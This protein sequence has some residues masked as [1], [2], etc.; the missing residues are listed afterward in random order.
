[1]ARCAGE[2]HK[3]KVTRQADFH[4][5]GG[6]GVGA[7][8]VGSGC[9]HARGALRRAAPAPQHQGV[10][11]PYDPIGWKSVWRHRLETFLPTYK[12]TRVIVEVVAESTPQ[13]LLQAYIFVRVM[14][15]VGV[16]QLAEHVAI[17]EEASILPISIAI[18]ALNLLKVWAELLLGAR[19]AGVP[20]Q[21]WLL[22]I[23]EMGAGK[24]PLDAIRRGTIKE[25]VWYRA[26]TDAEWS[27]LV[28][29]FLQNTS[30]VKVDLGAEQGGKLTDEQIA[31]LADALGKGAL[32][33]LT[34]LWLQQNR[35]HP[36]I[37]A[38]CEP[39]DIDIA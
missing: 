18:S 19:T 3:G 15:G 10:Q 2:G 11:V 8:G 23:W 37:V 31:S 35:S 28:D 21:A 13:S 20:M 5:G 1:V 12:A 33:N 27:M 6:V 29:A 30:L 14:A 26:M 9:A 34:V 25:L 24:L 36:Q 17:M 4:V 7:G 38:A 32:P 22:Q 39:R 16:D